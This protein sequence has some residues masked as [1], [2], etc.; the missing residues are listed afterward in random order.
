VGR[1][2]LTGRVHSAERERKGA[3]GATA[4]QLANW[5]HEA[6]R[7]KKRAGEETGADRSAP[8]SRERARE[9]ARER[10]LPLIGGV[11]LSGSPGARPGWAELGRL[12]CISFLFF[13]R[14]S[15]SFSISFL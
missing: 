9:S 13:S 10:E 5:A 2:D 6:E 1:A 4:Q 7:E 3:L 12:G 11:R 14:F 15:N 8:V